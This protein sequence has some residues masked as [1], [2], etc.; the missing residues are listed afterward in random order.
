MKAVWALVADESRARVFARIESGLPLQDID[1]ILP[2]NG[3]MKK[4]G[5]SEEND[6]TPEA[7]ARKLATYLSEARK[8]G[9]YD[10]L[11]LV[12]PSE[13]C[14]RLQSELDSSTRK[15]LKDSFSENLAVM[16]VAEIRDRLSTLIK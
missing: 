3:E 14:K 11:Y 16:R 9:E 15:K 1:D 6:R 13:F 4:N 5:D 2:G 12:A 7:F 8:S 10:S